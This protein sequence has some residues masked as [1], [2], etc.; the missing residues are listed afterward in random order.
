MQLNIKVAQSLIKQKKTLAIA[1]SCTGGLLSNNLTNVPGSSNFLLMSIIAYANAAKTKLLN[2]SPQLLKKHDAVSAPIARLMATNIRKILSTDYGIAITGIA[3][4]GG[5]SA[6]KPVGLV[7]I[8]VSN[9]KTVFV[10]Q[11][12]F[13]GSRLSIKRQA[14]NTA[15]NLLLKNISYV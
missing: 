7:F 5:G 9:K 6:S 10:E 11:C 2:I 15:L 8:A 14:S 12:I 4:P 13:K 3:G 1:E